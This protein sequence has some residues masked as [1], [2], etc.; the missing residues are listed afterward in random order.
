MLLQWTRKQDFLLLVGVLR[1]GYLTSSAIQ[2]DESLNLVPYMQ[3]DIK[4]CSSCLSY[5][6][7]SFTHSHAVLVSTNPA[8]ESF[9]LTK[10]IMRR[11]KNIERALMVEHEVCLA[12]CRGNHLSF[13]LAVGHQCVMRSRGIRNS[14]GENALQHDDRGGVHPRTEGGA[15]GRR[16]VR[17]G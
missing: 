3:N 10:F 8:H 7:V 2:T 1:H 15:H 4:G 5:L 16:R 11:M 13:S 9:L 14:A 12:A 6:S 17:R